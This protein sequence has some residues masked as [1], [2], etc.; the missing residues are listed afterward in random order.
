MNPVNTI[1]DLSQ[2]MNSPFT[3]AGIS[4]IVSIEWRGGKP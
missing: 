2:G 1:Q 4:G 3:G